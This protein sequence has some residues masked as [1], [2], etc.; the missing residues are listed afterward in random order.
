MYV[1]FFIF[2]QHATYDIGSS[3]RI[4]YVSLSSIVLKLVNI[5][6]AIFDLEVVLYKYKQIE[7]LPI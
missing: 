1:Y 4:I 6:Q 2:Q 3:D 7:V 5:K